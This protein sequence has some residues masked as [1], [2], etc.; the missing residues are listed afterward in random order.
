MIV[1]IYDTDSGEYALAAEEEF[2]SFCTKID[3]TQKFYERYQAYEAER[4]FIQSKL[5]TYYQDAQ[6][7]QLMK[8]TEKGIPSKGF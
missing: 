7:H 4:E 3:V 2:L 1:A 6:R 8:E 5:H